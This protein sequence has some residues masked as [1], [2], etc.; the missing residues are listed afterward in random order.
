MVTVIGGDQADLAKDGHRFV[1]I[2]WLHTDAGCEVRDQA[3]GVVDECAIQRDIEI[4]EF[5]TFRHV[6]ARI[7]VGV[8]QLA[9]SPSV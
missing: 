5:A 8:R 2:I 1:Q 7:A 6:A 3:C 4:G 9:A